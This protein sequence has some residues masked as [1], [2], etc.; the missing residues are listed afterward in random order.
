MAKECG[1][2]SPLRLWLNE[3][4]LDPDFFYSL[5]PLER[6]IIDNEALSNLFEFQNKASEKQNEKRKLAA[7]G[8][9]PYDS[10][11]DWLSEIEAANR[12]ED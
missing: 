4:G 12:G 7:K 2:G 11:D 10:V 6:L 9:E 5:S 1:A 8:I 3:Y